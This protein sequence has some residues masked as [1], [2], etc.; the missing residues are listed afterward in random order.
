MRSRVTLRL[1]I[2]SAL[3]SGLTVAGASIAQSSNGN[4]RGQQ[5]AQTDNGH[6]YGWYNGNRGRNGNGPGYGNENGNGNGNNG[7]HYG[8]R[9]GNAV[10]VP[11]PPII[12]L[13][14]TGLIVLGLV[15]RRR[16]RKM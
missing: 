15:G 13:M 3:I 2:A 9:N 6:H 1:A 12:A 4:N 16:L 14:A 5:S 11:E 8:H 7:N 10:S